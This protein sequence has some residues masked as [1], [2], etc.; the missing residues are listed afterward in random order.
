MCLDYSVSKKRTDK[1]FRV[2]KDKNGYYGYKEYYGCFSYLG[3]ICVRPTSFGKVQPVREWINE[4][5]VRSIDKKLD[6]IKDSKNNKYPK[7]FHVYLRKP[8]HSIKKI[9]KVYIR[10]I[11]CKGIQDRCHIVICKNIYIT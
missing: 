4:K 1:S 11:L 10:G 6:N 8:R 5:E 3:K 2:L 9:K 7:G